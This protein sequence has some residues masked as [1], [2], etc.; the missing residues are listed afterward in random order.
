M[1]THLK[2]RAWLLWLACLAPAAVAQ[3]TDI[4]WQR[5]SAPGGNVPEL[6]FVDHEELRAFKPTGRLVGTKER[7]PLVVEV[8]EASHH[9][10]DGAQP[11]S[12]VVRYRNRLV[13]AASGYRL[14]SVLIGNGV[15]IESWAGTDDCAFSRWRLEFAGERMQVIAHERF[16]SPNCSN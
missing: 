12:I 7:G 10:T 3:Q 5:A 2:R 4:D 8:R 14:G 11:A 1:H 13:A 9:A 6:V 16:R 15:V